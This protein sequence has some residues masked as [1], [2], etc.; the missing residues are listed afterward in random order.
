MSALRAAALVVLVALPALARAQAPQP[1][2]DEAAARAAYDA[3]LYHYNLSEWDAAI[4][5]FERAYELSRAPGLLFNIGQAQR[6]KG[7]EAAALSSYRAYLRLDANA[8]NRA[9]VEGRIAELERALAEKQ[10][11]AA[12]KPA[13]APPAPP[14]KAPARQ[15][16]V[17]RVDANVMRVEVKGRERNRAML[18]AGWI[19]AAAGVVV[20]G[21]GVYFAVRATQNWDRIENI[22]EDYERWGDVEQGYWDDAQRQESIAKILIGV[23]SAAVVTGGVL[24]VFGARADGGSMFSVS[25]RR[26]GGVVGATLS[27]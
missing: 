3:A 10:R 2:R 18:H 7:D 25:P 22:S 19:T 9:E 6:L 16:Q 12:A 26:G 24:Y 17:M 14:P 13:P 11:K 4:A 8:I 21:T 23:G 5:Q 20:I 15:S 27:F 1:K